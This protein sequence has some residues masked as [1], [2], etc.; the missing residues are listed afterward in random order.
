MPCF[1]PLSAYQSALIGSNGRFDITFNHKFASA[2]GYRSLNLPCGQCVGCRLERS[3]Q[4]AIRCVHESQLYSNNCFI[5]LTYDNAHLPEDR[6]LNV[7]H[8][9]D[10]MKRLRFHHRGLQPVIDDDGKETFPIRFFHCGE[11][12]EQLGRPHYHACL[13]NFDFPDKVFWKRSN[14]VPLFTSKIL[15]DLW[16]MGFVSIGSVTFESAAYVARYIMKKVTGDKA[17]EHYNEVDM[18][19]G[20]VTRCLKPEYITMSRRPG[21]ARRWFEKYHSDVYPAD[22]VVLR[23]RKLKPPKYYDSQYEILDPF[24]LD[25]VKHDRFTKSLVHADN[26]TPARLAVR[27]EVQLER[28]S[29]LVRNLR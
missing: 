6:S 25:A 22:L 14:G 28:L 8:F 20:E 5:T 3:R 21:I 11:Y 12:G 24:A 23:G 4:W 2:H 1:H 26:C 15:S 29:R 16:G 19:T 7:K 10:F 17:F 9:Q 27:E 18:H 13:F